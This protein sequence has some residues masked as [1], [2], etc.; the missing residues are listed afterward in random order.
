MTEK[1][2]INIS[3]DVKKNYDSKKQILGIFKEIVKNVI[4][5]FGNYFYSI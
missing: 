1:I 5:A 4:K 3:E 2:T